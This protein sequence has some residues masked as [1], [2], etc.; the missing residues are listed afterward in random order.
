[1]PGERRVEVHAR[2]FALGLLGDND[3][4]AIGCARAIDAGSSCI[5]E[6]GDALDVINVDVGHRL[7]E[8]S[9]LVIS[10]GLD[11][12][13]INDVEGIS[14]TIHRCGASDEP[15]LGIETGDLALKQLRQVV[16][17]LGL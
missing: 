4:H 6:H 7:V 1:M 9:I 8:S 12:E 13:A 3:H 17:A 10:C 15:T 11:G 2:T 16:V 14:D 5:L